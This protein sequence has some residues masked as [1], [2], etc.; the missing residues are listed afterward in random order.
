MSTFQYIAIA[1]LVLMVLWEL[2]RLRRGGVSSRL[3]LMR[4]GVWLAAMTAVSQ[5]LLL[6]KLANL[7]GIGR[8]ADVLL[9]L[10]VFAFF[11]SGFFLYAK[12]IQL[13]RQLTQLVRVQA[14]ATARRGNEGS[15]P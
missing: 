5:P 15:R 3:W 6:Q 13:Q 10:L 12:Y 14:I 9:Y 11:G 7:L 4:V 1:G 8:G 2:L